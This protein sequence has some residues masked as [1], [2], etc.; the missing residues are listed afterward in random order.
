VNEVPTVDGVDGAEL[1]GVTKTLHKRPIADVRRW[2]AF[3]KDG[4][5]GLTAQGGLG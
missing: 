5:G 2:F 1:T 4:S 3:R